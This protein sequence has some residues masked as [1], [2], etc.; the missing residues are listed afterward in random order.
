MILSLEEHIINLT[1]KHIINLTSNIQKEM[2]TYI[3]S[4][5]EARPKGFS[6]AL[7]EYMENVLFVVGDI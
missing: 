3:R 2:V 7:N 4:D 6:M 5:K 1:S